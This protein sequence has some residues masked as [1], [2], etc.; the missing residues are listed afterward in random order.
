MPSVNR[1]IWNKFSIHRGDNLP[2]SAFHG[3]R[4]KLPELFN[5]LGYKRGAEIGVE[6]GIFSEVICKGIPGLKLICV[7]PWK[8]YNRISQAMC[9]KYYQETLERLKPYD[10]EYKRMTSVEAVKT[11]PDESLDFVYIDAMHEFDFVMMDILTWVPKVRVGGIVSGHDYTPSSVYCGVMAAVDTYTR[12]HDIRK[13]YITMKDRG[14]PSFFW[15][16][17]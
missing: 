11:V 14:V 6:Q 1:T 12:E 17:K 16:K 2:I 5:E 4:N 8:A 13:W 3:G 7:D 9:D 10:V 15:V